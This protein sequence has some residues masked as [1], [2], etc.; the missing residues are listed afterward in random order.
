MVCTLQVCGCR[1]TRLVPH[2]L[3]HPRLLVH[4]ADAVYAAAARLQQLLVLSEEGLALVLKR[5][6]AA[7]LAPPERFTLLLQQ[8]ARDLAVAPDVAADILLQVRGSPCGRAA[9]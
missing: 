1:V 4:S 6:P 5:C 2:L 3:A 9:A 7:L 8:L